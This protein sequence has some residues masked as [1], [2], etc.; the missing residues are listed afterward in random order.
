MD[1]A[2][3]E[4]TLADLMPKS[5]RGSKAWIW[6]PLGVLALAVAIGLGY[7]FGIRKAPSEAATT[8]AAKT[9]VMNGSLQLRGTYGQWPLGQ[10][11]AGMGG[12]R[13]LVEGAQVVVTDKVGETVAIGKLATGT[14]RPDRATGAF[15]VCEFSF[16]IADVPELDFYGVEVSHR[17]RLQV[18]SADARRGVQLQLGS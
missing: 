11:C 1:R 6:A 4:M 12:F 18:T 3:D 8:P 10:S 13:D 15:N 17:G 2:Q 7:W 14:V 9:F 5:R 16:I